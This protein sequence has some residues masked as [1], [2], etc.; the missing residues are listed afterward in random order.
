MFTGDIRYA[1]QQSLYEYRN[2]V[3]RYLL[4]CKGHILE[5]YI[6][7]LNRPC[8]F[9]WEPIQDW[10]F[11]DPKIMYSGPVTFVG[12]NYATVPGRRDTVEF[13]AQHCQ[14]FKAWGSGWP[15]AGIMDNKMVPQ[16]YNNSFAVICENNWSDI[17]TYFTPRNLGAMAAGS[18]PLMKTFPN[19]G[20]YFKDWEDC[21]FYENKYELLDI[22]QYLKLNPEKRNWISKNAYISA[23]TS[24]RTSNY[25]ECITPL[26]G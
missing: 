11:I 14:E 12:N 5:R 6:R 18:C 21:I 9:M 23:M 15:F 4:P 13:L 10:R 2:V 25:V 20:R 26:L 19:I 17:D 24:W 7:L 22:I 16:Q 1:P 3:D 8:E